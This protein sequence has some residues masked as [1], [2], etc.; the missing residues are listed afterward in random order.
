MKNIYITLLL[1]VAYNLGY[2]QNYEWLNTSGGSNSDVDLESTI[3][4]NDNII[5]GGVFTSDTMFIRQ[6]TLV[7]EWAPNPAGFLIKN[8]SNGNILW[9]KILSSPTNLNFSGVSGIDTDSFG[10]VYVTGSFGGDGASVHFGNNV[11]VSTPDN[12]AFYVVK[13][14]PS[15]IAIWAKSGQLTNTINGQGAKGRSIVVDD[16]GN[17]YVG[18]NLNGETLTIDG[19]L[20]ITNP[21]FPADNSVIL[22]FAPNGTITNIYITGT[23]GLQRSRMAM[24]PDGNI[25]H[26]TQFENQNLFVGS[27]NLINPNSGTTHGVIIKFTPN[28]NVIWA[29]AFGSESNDEFIDVDVDN[30]GNI[31]VAGL[32]EGNL[33]QFG[34]TTINNSVPILGVIAKFNSEGNKLGVI[35][36]TSA[37]GNGISAF[38]NIDIVNHNEMYVSCLFELDETFLGQTSVAQ[39]NYISGFLARIDSSGE[40]LWMHVANISDSTLFLAVEH[41]QGGNIYLGGS[42]TGT[43]I[44]LGTQSASNTLTGPYDVF[45]T[46]LNNACSLNL[47]INT[48]NAACGDNSGSAL[49]NVTGGSGSYAYQWTSGD[50]TQTASS[51]IAGIYQVSIL[52]EIS[53]C[54]VS[55]VAMVSDNGGATINPSP[56]GSNHVTCP[57][58]NDGQILINLVG[59]Q[60]PRTISWSNGDTT[61]LINNLTAGPY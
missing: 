12:A 34:A 4:N 24:T 45:F 11:Q 43:G 13:F 8:N 5:Y 50:S 33:M 55:G 31:Y 53:G 38:T 47:S 23:E 36:T 30:L 16:L 26:V 48:Q 9:A 37:N 58:G 51:L 10:N 20:A 21:T 32:I 15:G 54:E 56:A 41:D 61:L 42:Y 46:K 19:Q 27:S 14:N 49:A 1:L 28:L 3:D 57:G 44:S 22:N 35:T 59:G 7:N 60:A 40:A 2:A 29:K 39:P 18:C 6:D 17:S 52:D 25:I